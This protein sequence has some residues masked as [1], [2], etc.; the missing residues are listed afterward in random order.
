MIAVV[1]PAYKVQDHVLGVLERIGPECARV[2]VVDDCC[3]NGSG[4]VVETQCTDP[5]VSVLRHDQNQGVGA[6]T[7]TG[8]RAA[9]ADGCEIVVKVDGDGQMDPALIP[10]LVRSIQ[11]GEADYTK[12]NRFYDLEGLRPMPALRLIGNAGLS[13]LNKLSSGYWNVF[14]P[15]N[16]FTAIHAKVLAA[17]PLDQVSKRWFF[18][19]DML[20]YMGLLRASVHDVPMPA[21]YGT[22]VSSLKINRVL[23]V[24][25]W[26]H[27]ANTMKRLFYSYYLRDFS[28]ASIELLLGPLLMAA[29]LWFGVSQW[30]D[31]YHANQFASSGTVMLAALPILMGLQ[32]VLAFLGY[33]VRNVPV[34][35]IHRRL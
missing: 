8:Y 33:D 23:T 24:F 15:T 7:I 31:A 34:H 27:F 13:F 35:A 3:P 28:V 29:G 4:K 14:D 17:L 5:R 9:L 20:F 10:R 1:I 32:F 25:A 12:G 6:A 21:R 11:S 22:E 26:G 2:Y 18:E 30:I 19:S 16:G